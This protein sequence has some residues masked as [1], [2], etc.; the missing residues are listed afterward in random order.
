MIM[1]FTSDIFVHHLV[2]PWDS[3][4]EFC[5]LQP[6]AIVIGSICVHTLWRATC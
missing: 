4:H 5:V 2:D 3:S 6:I 1:K